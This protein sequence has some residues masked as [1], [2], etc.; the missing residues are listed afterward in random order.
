MVMSTYDSV[1]RNFKGS[2]SWD[3]LVAS[4]L[5]VIVRNELAVDVRHSPHFG[6]HVENH[7]AVR[8]TLL[9]GG[10]NFIKV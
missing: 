8:V 5:R 1:Q 2:N 7:L 4:V 3:N 6:H 10:S 9:D